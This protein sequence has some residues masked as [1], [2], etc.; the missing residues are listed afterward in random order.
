MGFMNKV[1]F[2]L[3]GFSSRGR[4][5][6]IDYSPW[7]R[8]ESDTTERLHLHHHEEILFKIICL[9]IAC[10]VQK[11]RNFT[12]GLFSDHFYRV[13]HKIFFFTKENLNLAH[14]VIHLSMF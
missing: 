9:F 10:L 2:F 3:P 14:V 4:R 5:S 1:A 13:L 6:L 8:K 11:I 12:Y 7:G